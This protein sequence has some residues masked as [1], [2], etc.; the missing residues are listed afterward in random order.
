MPDNDTPIGL[1]ASP[2]PDEQPSGRTFSGPLHD[3]TNPPPQRRTG[4]PAKDAQTEEVWPQIYGRPIV[5]TD[6]LPLS[7]DPEFQRKQAAVAKRE[8]VRRRQV[9]ARQRELE[10]RLRCGTLRPSPEL[11]RAEAIRYAQAA[12]RAA[13]AS[14]RK[15]ELAAGLRPRGLRVS[16]P[17]RTHAP[18]RPGSASPVVGT[19]LS[20]SDPPLLGE[21]SEDP[22]RPR[23][24]PPDSPDHLL[25]DLTDYLRRT[26]RRLGSERD[27]LVTQVAFLG[28]APE[29]VSAALELLIAAGLARSGVG[30]AGVAVA[31]R[32]A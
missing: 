3:R 12:S 19:A 4:D 11:T 23:C 1:G 5:W 16:L 26:D 25:R 20:G 9:A 2:N 30:D 21:D 15:H 8:A 18:R 13:T 24:Q 29:R 27:W 6:E 17:R 31:R 28:H 32:P 22:P 14:A 10:Q 7:E